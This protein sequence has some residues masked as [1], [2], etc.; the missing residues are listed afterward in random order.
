MFLLSITRLAKSPINF[1]HILSP[2]DN[3]LI[4]HKPRE[5]WDVMHEIKI[6]LLH[7]VY[8]QVF[9]WDVMHEIKIR[10]LH[11]VYKQVFKQLYPSLCQNLQNKSEST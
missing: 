7:K 6:R 10:L 4:K 11:K 2:F 9:K 8:K 1:V 5:E 3:E